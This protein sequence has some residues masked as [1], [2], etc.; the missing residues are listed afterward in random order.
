M[1]DHQAREWPLPR[2]VV[3]GMKEMEIPKNT[4]KPPSMTA[5][6]AGRGKHQQTGHLK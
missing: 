2:R 6:G 3:F 1:E 4:W 5:I